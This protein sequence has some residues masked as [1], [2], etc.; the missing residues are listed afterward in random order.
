[1]GVLVSQRSQVLAAGRRKL[2]HL[3]GLVSQLNVVE[4]GLEKEG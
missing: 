2:E 3:T 1:M 4:E